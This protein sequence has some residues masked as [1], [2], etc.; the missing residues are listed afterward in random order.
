MST[1]E[2][3]GLMLVALGIF[4][5]VFVGILVI[6]ARFSGRVGERIQAGSF[7]LPAVLFII[8]GSTLR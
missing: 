7:V 6:A 8:V 4:A 1:V 3:L 5:V 2:K